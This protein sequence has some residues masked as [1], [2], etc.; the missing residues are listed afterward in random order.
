MQKPRNPLSVQ[1]KVFELIELTLRHYRSLVWPQG[2]C[3]ICTCWSKAE[4][5]LCHHCWIMQLN[6]RRAPS[7]YQS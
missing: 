7:R 2:S 5:I 3:K 1:G 6:H 4:A